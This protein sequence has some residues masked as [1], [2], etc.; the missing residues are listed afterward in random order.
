MTETIAYIRSS[1]K[2]LYPAGELQ[3]LVRL[4]MERVCGLSTY[5]L[6]SGKDIELSDTEKSKIKE[7]VK[8]LR[9]HEPIQYLLGVA[10]FYGMELKV[11][12]DVLIP[13][14][15]TAELADRVIR[16]FRGKVPRVLDIGTGSGCI[17]IAIAMHLPEAQVAA[18]DLSD[19]A[20][21]VARENARRHQVSISF[22]QW[23][24]LAGMPGDTM[25]RNGRGIPD[26]SGNRLQ[27]ISESW[28]GGELDCIVS[29]PPY[30][31]EWEKVEMEPNVLDYEPGIALFVPDDDPFRFYRAI[32]RFARR[33]LAD[34]GKLYLEISSRGGAGTVRLLEEERFSH[35]ELRK[36]LYGND[37][38][39]TA[40]YE[41]DNRT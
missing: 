15:E 11:T 34:G 40:I 12:P 1:L 13:R 4:I 20:L 18:I 6:L 31:P 5:Q 41:R 39:V 7:I 28:G 24:I 22:S 23:D 2:E 29:N 8:G 21:A 17:A 27:D 30:I 26:F 16:D 10:D 33:H 35:I 14:P 36:D 9:R 32:A 3:A 38:I 37:R 19:G 25:G